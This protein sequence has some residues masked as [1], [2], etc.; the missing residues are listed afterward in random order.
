MLKNILPIF[1][2][3]AVLFAPLACAS[4]KKETLPEIVIDAT[5]RDAALLLGGQTLAANAAL[6]PFTES[7]E[8][9]DW[10]KNVGAA[11]EKTQ[12]NNLVLIEE[13][14]K[15]TL[16]NVFPKTIFS[17]F[18]GPDILNALAFFP[19]GNDFILFGL[20]PAGRIP[21]PEQLDDRQRML[22]LRQMQSALSDILSVN[23]F[24]TLH[25]KEQVKEDSC[26][27]FSGII[28]F[29]LTRMN[30]EV[31]GARNIS[32]DTNGMITAEY[33]PKDSNLTPGS[34]FLFRQSSENN[35]NT[36]EIKRV[37]YFSLDI[38][39]Y[40]LAIKDNFEKFAQTLP[41][42]AAIIKSASFL[43]HQD[44]FSRAR[45]LVL[46]KSAYILQDDSGVPLRFFLNDNWTVD[47]FGYYDRPIPLFANRFQ[48]DLL[49]NMQS[50]SSGRLPFS[51]GY[52]HGPGRANLIL[53]GK[54][55]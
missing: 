24:Q 31:I 36:H 4:E 5:V 22:E 46:D 55:K 30:M 47:Y 38:A 54:N 8:Y 20:E 10:A 16:T 14:R 29:F 3:T 41:D 53:A 44:G 40:M 45:K 13:W 11:W 1:L 37:R 17:P 35:T 23:F 27:S 9:R 25:M 26:A 34:E 43:M 19:Q 32:I 15:S 39:D 18:S 52:T 42:C 48:R 49:T 51:Y 2:L 12:A 6:A 21:Q 28:M 33:N 7:A 50:K